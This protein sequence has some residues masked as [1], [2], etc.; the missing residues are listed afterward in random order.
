VR[1]FR[2]LRD[3]QRSWLVRADVEQLVWA[4]AETHPGLEFLRDSAEF[5]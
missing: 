3:P 5:R 4:V 1:L 2:V